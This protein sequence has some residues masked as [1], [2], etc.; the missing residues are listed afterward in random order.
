MGKSMVSYLLQRKYDSIT[1]Q[2]TK[3]KETAFYLALNADELQMAFGIARESG[4][5]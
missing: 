5:V 1:L 3:D 4:D 2:L